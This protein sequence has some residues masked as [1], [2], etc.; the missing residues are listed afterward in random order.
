MWQSLLEGGESSQF[1]WR[2]DLD[3]EA[4]GLR[5]YLTSTGRTASFVPCGESRDCG[6]RIIEGQ[7]VGRCPEGLCDPKDFERSD[8]A[9]VDVDWATLLGDLGGALGLSGC[10][11]AVTKTPAAVQL[12][13][14]APVQSAR[15]AVF[16]CAPTPFYPAFPMIQRFAELAAGKPFVLVIASRAQ[17]DILSL[18]VLHSRKAEAVF[19]DDEVKIDESGRLDALGAANRLVKFALAISG[20]TLKPSIP[21]FPTPEGAQ[22]SDITILEVDGLTIEVRACV[23]TPSGP[24]EQSAKYTYEALGLTKLVGGRQVPSSD[25]A[26]LVEILRH[27]R[28]SVDSQK[29]WDS[30][31]GFRNN[32]GGLLQDLTGLPSSGAFILHRGRRCYE[33]AF[34]VEC[35]PGEEMTVPGPPRRLNREGR[36]GKGPDDE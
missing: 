18:G 13:W 25:C 15:F 6:W 16:F 27:R 20:V 26:F 8:L 9:M 1:A 7:F 35:E 10:P 19:L 22:W 5:K 28:V 14:I 12:G 17:L 3:G 33:A 29:E 11:D 36:V 31:R 21:K 32:I 24:R 34:Q 4:S 2:Q 23:K 30:L